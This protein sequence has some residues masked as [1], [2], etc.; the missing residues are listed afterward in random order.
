MTRAPLH[1]AQVVPL[2]RLG[3]GTE[4]IAVIL[5]CPVEDVERI[6]DGLRRAGR[7]DGIYRGKG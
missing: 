5:G 3:L 7:L 2:M 1:P 4:D 6:R